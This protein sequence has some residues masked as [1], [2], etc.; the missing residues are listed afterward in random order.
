LTP[1]VDEN[2]EEILDEPIEEKKTDK[3]ERVPIT[4]KMVAG[5]TT[6]LS[7]LVHFTISPFADFYSDDNDFQS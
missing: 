2:G 6:T 1:K 7:Q 3:D 4:K 5:M